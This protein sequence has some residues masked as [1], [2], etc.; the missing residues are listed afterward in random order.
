MQI[1]LHIIYYCSNL[2]L[3]RNLKIKVLLH[4]T[5]ANL[6]YFLA[7]FRT[8]RL[9]PT[10]SESPLAPKLHVIKCEQ[11]LKFFIFFIWI[12]RYQD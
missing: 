4:P 1:K 8:L 2:F 10:Q 9:P 12:I 7:W 3:R 6:G 11:N 5:E